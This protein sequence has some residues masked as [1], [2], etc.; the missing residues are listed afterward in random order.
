MRQLEFRVRMSG[1]DR[2]G[3]TAEAVSWL[4]SW[5]GECRVGRGIRSGTGGDRDG[6]G[7]SVEGTMREESV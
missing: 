6:E 4:S 7:I 2:R 1:V 3:G 5:D